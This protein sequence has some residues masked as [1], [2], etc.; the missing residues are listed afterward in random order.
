MG[1]SGPG[2]ND[3]KTAE[4]P[5]CITSI[6]DTVAKTVPKLRTAFETHRSYEGEA[7]PS[8]EEMLAAD[9]YADELLESRLGK[10]ACVGTYASE[11]RADPVS[12]GSGLSV[13]VDP[14][15]GSSNLSSNNGVGTIVGVYDGGLPASGRDLIGAM[16]VL[17]G[18]T[19]T[20]MVATRDG[21]TEYLLTQGEREVLTPSVS[22]PETGTV[23]G[24]GG[25]VPEWSGAFRRY[26]MSVQRRLKRRYG[27]ALVADVNQVLS[28]GGVFAY[29]RLETRP[30]GKLRLQFEA[31]PIAFIVEQAGGLSYQGERSVLDT[32]P[33][34]LHQRT[35]LF[36]GSPEP[37]AELIE[38]L[39]GATTDPT[40]TTRESPWD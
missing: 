18:P 19:T 38:T 1:T 22:L 9:V 29:P 20:A 11:E 30:S 8:G 27:G 2:S 37:L 15:D 12:I 25:P 7:N 17:Y 23:Y 13:A 32:E 34:R 4:E 10:L 33:E 3:L 39:G 5:A 16:Y 21:V 28:H 14:L 31:N 24:F 35:P 26:S 36:V 40:V 6:V